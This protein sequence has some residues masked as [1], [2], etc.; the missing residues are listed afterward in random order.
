MS[1]M[2]HNEQLVMVVLNIVFIIFFIRMYVIKNLEVGCFSHYVSNDYLTLLSVVPM[3]IS[4][5][6]FHLIQSPG[7]K[8]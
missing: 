2:I 6:S 8:L 7:T 4:C 5:I 1:R 3:Q